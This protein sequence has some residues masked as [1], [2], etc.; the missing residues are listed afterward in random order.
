M[1][2]NIFI[3]LVI[4]LIGYSSFAHN[5]ELLDSLIKAKAA[6]YNINSVTI[7]LSYDDTVYIHEVKKFDSNGNIIDHIIPSAH[8]IDRRSFKYDS[9]SRKTQFVRFDKQDTSKIISEV[10]YT[11]V[12]STY[13]FSEH[14]TENHPLYEINTYKY[15]VSKDT[16]WVEH[17][18]KRLKYNKEEKSVSRYTTFGDTL[19][20]S[21]FIKYNSDGK[22]DKIKAHYT[23]LRKDSAGNTIRTSGQYYVKADEIQYI[24]MKD[25][26]ENQESYLQKQLDGEYE[27]EYGEDIYSYMI[28]NPSGQLIQNGYG[29]FDKQTY[30]YNSDKQLIKTTHWDS[31]EDGYGIVKV[32]TDNY[33]YD[34]RGLP[35]SIQRKNL[36]NEVIST[37]HYSFK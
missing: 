22:M 12:D 10:N 9:L 1:K 17:I 7:K 2:L 26:F 5:G 18:E 8:G 30:E 6:E 21:E 16:F 3:S 32:A 13:Y 20:V 28:Y 31:V 4:T 25:Y 15:T 37:T 23:L 34:D 29:I 19:S 36:E 14:S 33:S 24:S 11:Y 27:Y 35:I